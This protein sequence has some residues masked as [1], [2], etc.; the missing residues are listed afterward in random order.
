MSERTS[1]AVR[2]ARED[3]F[4]D[5]LRL[6]S[7]EM[8][9]AVDAP[10]VRMGGAGATLLTLVTGIA[11]IAPLG[12]LL[13][14]LGGSGADVFS[15]TGRL[16]PDQERLIVLACFWLAA[17]GQVWSLIS[18]WRLDRPRS[19]SAVAAAALAAAASTAAALW[20]LARTPEP[21]A[22]LLPI[23]LTGLLGL[24][25]LVARLA[26]S[27]AETTADV[28]RRLVAEQLRAL[29]SEQQHALL[30]ERREILAALQQRGLVDDD[31]A[32][33]AAAAPIGEW[34]RIDRDD[35]ARA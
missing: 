12:G 26:L 29:P 11:L 25:G 34:W 8:Q 15:G 18:W 27:R 28:R 35:S 31:L 30:A 22:L 21:T 23:V 24:V 3:D 20:H 19:G 14:P 7:L 16:A 6:G 1:A 2:Q 4:S 32:Q 9:Q 13:A 10:G 33:R 5:G 17:V